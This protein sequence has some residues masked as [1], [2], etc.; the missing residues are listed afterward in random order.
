L[1]F[2]LSGIYIFVLHGFTTFSGVNSLGGQKVQLV[3]GSHF[4]VAAPSGGKAD[5]GLRA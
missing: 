4:N 2:V 3:I 5:L 1:H